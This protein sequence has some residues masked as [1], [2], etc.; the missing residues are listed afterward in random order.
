MTFGLGHQTRFVVHTPS[1][2]QAPGHG[3]VAALPNIYERDRPAVAVVVPPFVVDADAG[4]TGQP[5]K[6][7]ER[8]NRGA[9]L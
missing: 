5:N 3:T 1:G 2:W 9:F 7:V 6:A 4:H 8:P